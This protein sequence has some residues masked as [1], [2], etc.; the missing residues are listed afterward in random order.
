[1][2]DVSLVK[3]EDR[4]HG[5]KSSIKTLG[6]NPARGK[7]VLIKPNFNT[8]DE[9]P[10][11][12]HNDTLITLVDEI[13]SMGAKSISLG[14]R[15]FPPTMDIMKQKGILPLLKKQNVNII[16]FD[17]LKEK[18]WI[19]FNP[20]DSHWPNGFRIARPVLETECL[21]STCCLKT[22]QFGGVFTLSLKLHVGAV[23]CDRN[24]YPYMKELHGSSHMGRM[25]AEINE[26]FSPAL[27][28]LDGIDAFVDGG[29]MTGKRARG[30]VLL[31]SSDRVAIDAVGVAILKVLGSN[32]A[33]MGTEIFRQEQISRA[34]ELGLGAASPS[35][36]N[37]IPADKESRGYCNDVLQVLGAG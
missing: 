7:D 21:V 37:L 9:P 4:I 16:D 5:V 8:A 34:A 24:G 33:I 3:T 14:E 25:I 32:D 28:V 15:S 22:H 31:A 29:P 23:P 6:I 30:D 12:T 19:E 2:S 20:S 27:I 17:N 10:G 26:P 11:S 35:E 1:M 36:I 18:D 13:W